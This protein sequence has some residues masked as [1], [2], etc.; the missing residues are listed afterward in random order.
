MKYIMFEHKRTRQ[1]IPVIFP[2]NV[3]H[4]VM[5]HALKHAEPFNQCAL[6][7]AGEYNGATGT[8]SGHSSTL[9][10][11]SREDDS[12]IISTMDYSHGIHK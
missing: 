11:T 7:S 9:K 4:A 6:V 10:L 1:N 2:N 8:C 5:A 3:V 12:T